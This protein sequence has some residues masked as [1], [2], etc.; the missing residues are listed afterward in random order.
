MLKETLAELER[1]KDSKE[2]P[3]VGRDNDIGE[4]NPRGKQHQL[5]IGGAE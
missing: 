1:A 4:R 3:L 5:Y 2:E